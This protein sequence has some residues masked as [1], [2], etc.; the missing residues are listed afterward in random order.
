MYKTSLQKWRYNSVYKVNRS[1]KFLKTGK[2]KSFKNFIPK[3][4]F[5]FPPKNGWQKKF[6]EP[7]KIKKQTSL[8]STKP[9]HYNF[10]K[11][12]HQQLLMP[13]KKK[14]INYLDKI[15]R[16][17]KLHYNTTMYTYKAFLV[18]ELQINTLLA[19]T[20]LIPF[21]FLAQDLCYY[22][23]VKVNNNIKKNPYTL[24]TLYNTLSIPV[25]FYN[26][27]Y[28]RQYLLQQAP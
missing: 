8:I 12:F 4:F 13:F 27:M 11:I 2:N 17:Y 22:N 10:L 7:K 18:M 3:A 19:R 1:L 9:Y 24:V 5:R 15:I 21:L 6:V 14:G 28:C 25:A 16:F 26:L 23:L 20:K